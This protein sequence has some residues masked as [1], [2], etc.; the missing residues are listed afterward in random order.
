MHS[1]SAHRLNNRFR[2]AGSAVILIVYSD[3][4]QLRRDG[5]SG[6]GRIRHRRRRRRAWGWRQRGRG[7]RRRGESG[8]WRRRSGA[9]RRRCGRERARHLELYVQARCGCSLIIV[10]LAKAQP[11]AHILEQDHQG[12]SGLF[13]RTRTTQSIIQIDAGATTETY[14]MHLLSILY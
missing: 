7:A 10:P 14:C 1:G 3:L 6:R 11:A 13:T 8:S 2:S 12:I 9:R 4:T 5:S